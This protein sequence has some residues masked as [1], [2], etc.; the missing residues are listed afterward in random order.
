[1]ALAFT[2]E[3]VNK[4]DR[5]TLNTN[6]M[7]LLRDG[8]EL[9]QV[10]IEDVEAAEGFVVEGTLVYDDHWVATAIVAPD[11][12]GEFTFTLK[13]ET[14]SGKELHRYVTVVVA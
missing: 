1:M 7:T 8:G 11:E 5:F 3:P 14:T 10:S 9:S 12:S 2:L 13:F 4:K 6:C